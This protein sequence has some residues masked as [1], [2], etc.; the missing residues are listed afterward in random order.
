MDIQ[1]LRREIDSIDNRIVKLLNERCDLAAQVGQWK[2]QHGQ[3]F[4]VPEREKNLYDRLRDRN[5]GPLPQKGLKAIYRE[6]ISAAISLEKPLKIAA[7]SSQCGAIEAAVETFGSSSLLIREK[8]IRNIVSSVAQSKW[9]Y[10]VL[11]LYDP[12][13]RHDT[14]KALAGF[15]EAKICAKKIGSEGNPGSSFIIIGIQATRPCSEDQTALLVSPSQRALSA[16]KSLVGMVPEAM[17]S[18][19]AVVRGMKPEAIFAEINGHLSGEAVK[20]MLEDISGGIGPCRPLGSF[21]V[22]ASYRQDEKE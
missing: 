15:P 19:A 8:D 7:L 12:A 9:D 21:P 17:L 3:P 4:Y 5:P 1:G 16:L 6:I 13:L 14:L 10:G 18:H 11:P 20:A 2:R 22:F